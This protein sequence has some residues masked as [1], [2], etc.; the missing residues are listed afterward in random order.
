[1]RTVKM[2]LLGLVIALACILTN[3]S[4]MA[5]QTNYAIG[6]EAAS[7]LK[8][9]LGAGPVGMGEAF[10]GKADDVNATAWNPAG[11]AQIT[12]HQAGFMHN[13]YLQETSLEY[14]AYAQQLFEGAG[15][16]VNVM[17]LNYGTME[18]VDITSSGLPEIVGEFTPW[19]AAVTLGYGQT[20]MTDLS[21]GGSVKIVAQ[22]IDEESYSAFAVDLAALYKV[23]AVEGLQ[24]G[25]VIQNLGSQM[26]DASLPMNIK[27]GAAYLLPIKANEGDALTAVLD[28]NLPI[29]DLNYFSAN[30]GAEYIYNNL[31]AVRVGYKIKDAGELD[32]LVGLTA[33]A[34]IKLQM[35]NLDYALVS[36]GDLGMTHQI[37]ASVGF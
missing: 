1:M 10:V 8:I 2:C 28:I 19:L 25:L 14:V 29:N 3:G 31:A 32:G 26:G 17:Y 12:N 11:L 27:A 30:V 9:P 18:K 4:V 16:G 13:I 36:Y 7:E 21:V 24:T 5:D 15:A 37:M 20:V 34:G 22:N 35:F 6:E 23:A 33:G